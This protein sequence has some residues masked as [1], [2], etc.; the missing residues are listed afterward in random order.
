MQVAHF[1]L[2][3]SFPFFSVGSPSFLAAMLMVLVNHYL[4]FSFFGENYYPF[5]EV[6]Y[7]PTVQKYGPFT[8]NTS[9]LPFLIFVAITYLLSEVNRYRYGTAYDLVNPVFRIRN[10]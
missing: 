1:S 7:L 10:N 6:S 9:T 5:S 4:A 3:S 8:Q 2:L